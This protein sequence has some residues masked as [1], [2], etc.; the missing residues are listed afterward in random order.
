MKKLFLILLSVFALQSV[1]FADDDKPIN[2]N[3][4]PIKSQEFIK[5]HFSNHKT[6]FAK[7][8]NE[9]WDK[10]YTVIFTNGESIE[11]NKEGEWKDIECKTT[12]IP[13]AIIPSELMVQI[14]ERYPKE[15]VLKIERDKKYYEVKLSNGLELKFTKKYKL[16]EVDN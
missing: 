3:Q 7:V 2:I 9:L 8:E 4:L 1:S 10:N 5:K 13:T 12:G 16:V 14:K 15:S 6:S 11:F